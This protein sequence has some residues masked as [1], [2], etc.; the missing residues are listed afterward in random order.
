[1]TYF[2]KWITTALSIAAFSSP[3]FAQSE[4]LESF[5]GGETV[6]ILIGHP[7]GGTFNLYAQLAAAHLGDHIPGNPEVIV[8]HMPGGGGSLAAAF[9]SNKAPTD[10]TMI[11]ILPETLTIKQVMAPEDS[12]WDM[13]KMRYI[14]RFTDVTSV[15]G[16]RKG[17]PATTVEGL[18]D[19][20]GN[21]ACSGTT[22]GSAQTGALARYFAGFNL[23]MVCGY[24]TATAGVLAILRGEADLTS[25]IWTNWNATQREHIDSGA[26]IPVV[27]FGLNPIEAIAD[28]P[29]AMDLVDDPK[30]RAALQ[31]FAASGEVGRA[32]LG[33]PDM[34]EAKYQMFVD[35]FAAMI[36]DPTFIA[37]AESSK[38][39][40]NIAQADELE[41]IKALILATP[42]DETENL[43]V[44]LDE[45]FK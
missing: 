43:K 8:Q 5:Y 37:D 19:V 45:G 3:V 33:S 2:K 28:V 42:D 40:L 10:G 11:A 14:G 21:F 26:V 7:P 17:A 25:T 24:D 39:P 34:E 20:G 30:A 12:L 29:L 1:M 13:N 22:T 16:V 9:F 41:E 38:V 15:M 36:E 18:R 27:Q 44:A 31:L 4:G 32:L 35:A 23:N 6:T